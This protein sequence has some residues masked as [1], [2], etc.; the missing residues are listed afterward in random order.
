[1]ADIIDIADDTSFRKAEEE[2]QRLRKLVYYDELTGI[3]N[4]RG[5]MEEAQH[6]FHL[7]SYGTTGIERRTGFQIP[8]SIVFFDI[9]DFKQVNDSYGHVTGDL[10]LKTIA[11]V[12]RMNLRDGDLYGRWGGEEFIVAMLGANKERAFIIADK[13]RIALSDFKFV[14]EG[15]RIPLTASFGSA[16][17]GEE[18]TLQELIERAD[19]AMYRA[20]ET[21]KNRVIS[22][23]FS[24]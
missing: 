18:K 21:G 3:F 16:T 1:M 4:R 23:D 12:L 2:L 15:R 24:S 7:V 6:Q 5:F 17:Y 13:I 9:D 11:L 10:A 19:K 22:A 8:F 20:K 14:V